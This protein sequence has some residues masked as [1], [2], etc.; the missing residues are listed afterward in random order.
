[1][2][3]GNL[4]RVRYARQR[5]IPQYLDATDVSWLDV[6]QAL[7]EIFRNH[8]GRTRGEL[9][10]ELRELAGDHPNQL[11]YQGLAK[12]LEDRCDFET[13][14]EHPPDQLR[15]TTFLTAAA[16]R[17]ARAASAMIGAPGFERA[18]V[19]QDVAAQT[20]LA[21]E[22]VDSGLFADLKSEQR[23]SRFKDLSP[24]RLLQRY[25]VALAQAVVLRATQVHV[26]IRSEPPQRYRQLF[27]RVKFHRLVCNI[28]R[29][30]PE[31]YQLHL[32]GPLSLFTATQKYGLQLAL[33]LPAVLLCQ[34]F[35]LEA[36]LLWG[37]E[38]KPRSF[39]VSSADGLVSH[40]ADS[41]MY[42]P[43][44]LALFVEL[45]RKR[46][47]GWQISED[48]EVRTLPDGFWIPDFRLFQASTGRSVDLEVLGFWRRSS[49]ERHLERLRQHIRE[50][51]LLAVSEQLHVEDG[52]LDALPAH[53]YRFRQLP[54]PEELVRLAETVAA[55]PPP[56]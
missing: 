16:A 37:P 18:I 52:E 47:T 46:I 48:P 14:S 6:S 5:I 44:E 55:T 51:F 8:L 32:D 9:T 29:N 34:D 42:L 28:S 23:L 41:G 1:M 31:G 7:L 54:L 11:I 35:E 17:K 38:R 25:N 12:L 20:G 50:P 24:E 27:R 33:F 39:R 10:E 22:A 56:V 2:L 49:V 3:T 30:E 21:L 15:E 36:E 53:I 13:V 26:T 45:F 40:Y 19:L 43:P 4:L